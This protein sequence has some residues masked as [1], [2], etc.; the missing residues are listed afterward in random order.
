[1][2][3]FIFIYFVCEGGFGDEPRLNTQYVALFDNILHR[4]RFAKF[5]TIASQEFDKQ[6][7]CFNLALKF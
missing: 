4:V 7:S 1:M 2:D 3:C 5:L 6:V